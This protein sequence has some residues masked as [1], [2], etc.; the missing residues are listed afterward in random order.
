MFKRALFLVL[1]AVLTVGLVPMVGAQDDGE[2]LS[3]T[4]VTIFGA[5]IDPAE[6]EAFN[7]GFEEFEAETGIDVVYE[8]A[9]TVRLK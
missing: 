1:I 3:G 9:S 4:T 5:Y 2:D 8:G 6:V 7:A